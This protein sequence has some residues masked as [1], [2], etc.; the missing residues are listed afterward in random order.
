MA[1]APAAPSSAGTSSNT[2]GPSKIKH[3]A[4]Q[5]DQWRGLLPAQLRWQD[6]SSLAFTGAENVYTG[7]YPPSQILFSSNLDDPPLS[8][9]YVADIQAALIRSRYFYARYLIHRPYIYKALHHPEAL[10]NEDAEGAAECLTACLKWPIIMSP[11]CTNKRLIP[12]PSF[13]SR[14][15][16]GV[17]VLLHLSQQHPMLLRVRTSFCG[18]Q[19]DFDASET[20]DLCLD[21]LRDMRRI[22][23]TADRCWSLVRSLYGMEE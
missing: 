10:T 22:D 5:L 23:T 11:T 16:F 12:L 21:W 20:A 17:L 14:N 9:S 18:Q 3:M 2:N 19:F 6:N 7:V 8:Y 1:S 4:A 13:W 15:V